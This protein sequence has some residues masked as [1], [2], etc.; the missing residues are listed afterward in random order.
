M[1]RKTILIPITIIL[2]ILTFLIFV[3]V[4]HNY[5]EA[6]ST[7]T[8]HLATP[9]F[10]NEANEIFVSSVAGNIDLNSGITM[11]RA[12]PLYPDQMG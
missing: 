3:R 8:S 2:V 5:Q 6:V 11:E 4:T 9:Y 10:S 1:M 12:T 7:P